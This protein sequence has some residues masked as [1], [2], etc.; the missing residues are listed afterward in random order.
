MRNDEVLP[1]YR[2]LKKKVFSRFLKVIFD[3]VVSAIALFVLALP[4]LII[5]I[6]IKCDS[7]GP[8]YYRQERFTRYRKK[9]RIFKFRTM[10]YRADEK[11]S[12]TT[13]SDD[14]RI[15]KYGAFLRRT[16]LDELPQIIN[17]FLGQMSFVGVRPQ[18]AKWVDRY[19]PKMEA[20]FLLRA[21]I[22]SPAS[23]AFKG[24][25]D[26]LRGGLN[27]DEVYF[28]RILP[29]KMALNFR[30]LETFNFFR[31]IGLIFRTIF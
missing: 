8:V 2:S 28:Q 20:T 10:V 5:A 4:F 15:T 12:L 22:T 27:V 13:S 14:P 17:V 30:Y 24:E 7:K 19:S 9:F 16:K 29:K 11:G 1:F 3:F 26:L 21:G 25:D 18:I 31:D 23:I 6:C